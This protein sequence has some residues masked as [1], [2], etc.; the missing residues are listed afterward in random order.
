MREAPAIEIIDGLLARGAGVR[1]TDPV[2]I[3]RAREV[4]GHRVVLERDSYKILEGAD[5][6]LLATEWNEYR[7]PDFERMRGL[8]RKPVLFDGRNIWSRS[9]VEGLGF[10]YYGIGA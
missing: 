6:L 9:L 5:G 7:F 1:A 10:T 4:L 2:A 8:L 3:Y